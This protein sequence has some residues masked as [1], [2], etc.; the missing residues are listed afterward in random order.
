MALADAE[1]ARRLDGQLGLALQHALERG[2]VASEKR[3][4]EGGLAGKPPGSLIGRAERLL[5]G[6]QRGPKPGLQA[7]VDP[8][9]L[10]LRRDGRK[11]PE[12]RRQGKQGQQQEVG[13]EL[14]F[15]TTQDFPSS[16]TPHVPIPWNEI[17]TT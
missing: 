14:D 7:R 6:G 9:G 2:A 11:A 13:D 4:L 3:P 1:A 17:S 12:G 8:P 15:E 10:A 16:Y 5:V